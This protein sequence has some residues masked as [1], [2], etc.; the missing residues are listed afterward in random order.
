MDLTAEEIAL[1]EEY[2]KEKAKEEERRRRTSHRLQIAK[3]YIEWLYANGRG[4]TFST[5][6]DEFGYGRDGEVEHY[7]SPGGL[8]E[9][10][11]ELIRLAE[12]N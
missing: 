11:L 12:K 9:R 8:Y 6:V 4:T 1:V 3:D 2:R 10:V 5:F 7:E